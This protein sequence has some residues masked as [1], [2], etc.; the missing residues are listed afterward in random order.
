MYLRKQSYNF[1]VPMDLSFLFMPEKWYY[2]Y[3]MF[4]TFLILF[5]CLFSYFT[6]TKVLIWKFK[7]IIVT[8]NSNRKL[9][10]EHH[11]RFEWLNGVFIS[12]ILFIKSK[13]MFGQDWSEIFCQTFWNE[14]RQDWLFDEHNQKLSFY[15]PCHLS[16]GQLLLWE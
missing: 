11:C 2:F 13:I 16:V 3:C 7:I 9:S 5:V 15:L 6:Y 12:K 4:V 10:N 8:Y 1:F 14:N